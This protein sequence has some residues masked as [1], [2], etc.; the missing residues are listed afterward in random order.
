MPKAILTYRPRQTFRK[1]ISEV[2]Y[3]TRKKTGK[4]VDHIAY[5]ENG[6]IYESAAPMGVHS[7]PFEE[8]KKGREGTTLFVFDLPENFIDLGIFETYH[9]TPYDY[10]ANILYYLNAKE[11]RLKKNANKKLFCSEVFMMAAHYDEPWTW[12]PGGCLEE[13]S[14]LGFPLKLQFL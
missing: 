9:G 8:W 2:N 1:P 14:R 3:R 6:R 12:T 5:Y 10:W 13:L 4:P 11:E 7:V